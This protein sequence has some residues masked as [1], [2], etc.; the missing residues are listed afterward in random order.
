M[1]GKNGNIE[2]KIRQY[3]RT[4]DRVMKFHNPIKLVI[5]VL[6]TALY[7]GYLADALQ[8][9]SLQN[10]F[11]HVQEYDECPCKQVDLFFSDVIQGDS[12]KACL[13]LSPP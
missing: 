8:N 13:S 4:C 6:D 9:R 2:Y 3:T 12:S 5:L 11:M 10:E 1:C 7:R